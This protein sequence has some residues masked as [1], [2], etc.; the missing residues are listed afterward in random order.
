MS[1]VAI[2]AGSRCSGNVAVK[3][4]TCVCRPI[5][6]R[7]CNTL[8]RNF[9]VDCNTEWHSSMMTRSN[10]WFN[11]FALTKS[12]N[13]CDTAD[14]AITNTICAL[15]GGARLSLQI[16]HRIP[17]LQHRSAMSSC[18]MIFGMTTI[19]TL[20]RD[21]T[22]SNINN[23]LLPPPVR[24]T[25]TIRGWPPT[26]ASNASR[27]LLRNWAWALYVFFNYPSIS[28]CRICCYRSN[29]RLSCS[30]LILRLMSGLTFCTLYDDGNCI[31]RCQS[32]LTSR[33]AS[34]SRL[35]ANG[36]CYNCRL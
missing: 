4:T 16:V 6:S 26:I 21:A 23:K 9:L 35:I 1:M 22:A 18:N 32:T 24:I 2:N 15:Y 19:V 25:T 27:C 34:C 3:Q 13:N 7:N 31:N 30:Y 29:F 11:I 12:A 28:I 14:S 10:Y 36:F 8:G 17:S 33:N 5:N 20:S